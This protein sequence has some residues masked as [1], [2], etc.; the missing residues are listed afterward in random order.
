[1]PG[2]TRRS[3][4]L[5]EIEKHPVGGQVHAIVRHRGFMARLV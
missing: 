1:M 4:P 3:E 2:I 5:K